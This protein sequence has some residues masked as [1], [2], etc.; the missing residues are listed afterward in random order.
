[1]QIRNGDNTIDIGNISKD[2][3]INITLPKGDVYLNDLPKNKDG[4]I[5]IGD[6]NEDTT[7]HMYDSI[8]PK[9]ARDSLSRTGNDNEAMLVGLAVL[10]FGGMVGLAIKKK[11]Q[12]YK[13][14]KEQK[15]KIEVFKKGKFS[16]LKTILKKLNLSKTKKK[17]VK[18]P[19]SIKRIK[20]DTNRRNPINPTMYKKRKT[21]K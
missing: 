21:K 16:V 6:I 9:W 14:S 18:N 19:K 5:S 1:M 10:G 8:L 11:Y 15:E 4:S 17:H 2:S 3:D 7:L 20:N 12:N 13:I